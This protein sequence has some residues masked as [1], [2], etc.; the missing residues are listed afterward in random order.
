MTVRITR[1]PG[2]GQEADGRGQR[3]DDADAWPPWDTEPDA[4]SYFAV[5]EA[6]WHFGAL[7]QE[8]ARWSSTSRT[9]R[10][11]RLTSTGR[12]ANVNDEECAAA[13][14]PVTRWQIGGAGVSATATCR[15][16]PLSG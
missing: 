1:G 5:A 3:C 14:S 12:A 15:R 13:I 4:R 11:R 9:G 16:R 7:T 6:G 10:G 8:P 2:A